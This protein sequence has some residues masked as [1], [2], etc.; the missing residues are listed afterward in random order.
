M[1]NA[2]TLA[3][4]LAILDIIGHTGIHAWVSLH[5]Q[6][7][8]RLMQLFVAGLK[9]TVEPS[10]ETTPASLLVSTVLEATTFWITGY[11]GARLYNYLHPSPKASSTRQHITASYFFGAFHRGFINRFLHFIGFISLAIGVWNFNVVLIL[12]AM[13]T[14]EAGHIYQHYVVEKGKVKHNLLE[15]FLW[16]IIAGGIVFYIF[17]LIV[18]SLKNTLYGIS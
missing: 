1:I 5:P 15:I 10:I 8:E 9:L 11:A 14:Q 18:L 13:L 3:N 17:A 4:T 2:I 12:T 7:Y 16:Q 6:S